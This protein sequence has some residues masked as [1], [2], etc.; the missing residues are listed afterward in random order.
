M[1]VVHAEGLE[2]GWGAC[3]GIQS[4]S[5]A[6]ACGSALHVML[7]LFAADPG[8]RQQRMCMC[9][10]FMMGII[11]RG[12]PKQH[13]PPSTH[14]GIQLCCL[15]TLRLQCIAPLLLNGQLLTHSVRLP[16]HATKH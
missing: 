6:A 15:V 14:L 10:A 4:P 9:Y 5:V 13:P 11:C 16:T 2:H 7:P 1:A 8:K 12:V 3:R